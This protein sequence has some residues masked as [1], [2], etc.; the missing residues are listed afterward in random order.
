MSSDSRLRLF[1]NASKN[2]GDLFHT[3]NSHCKF[4]HNFLF[5][6][7]PRSSAITSSKVPFSYLICWLLIL[8]LYK[9]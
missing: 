2:D 6:V 5:A 7:T 9:I 8:L 4:M 3:V 1:K